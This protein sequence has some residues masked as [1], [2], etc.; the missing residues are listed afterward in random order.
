MDQLAEYMSDVI[1]EKICKKYGIPMICRSELDNKELFWCK[2]DKIAKVFPKMD[3]L[4]SEILLRFLGGVRYS[5]KI[6]YML[7]QWEMISR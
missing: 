7:Q 1:Y 4:D 2:V 3:I 6:R 5:N